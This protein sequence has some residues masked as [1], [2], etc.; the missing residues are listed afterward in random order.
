MAKTV[1]EI[2]VHRMVRTPD[3]RTMLLQ[4]YLEEKLA[5]QRELLEEEFCPAGAD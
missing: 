1:G 2:P 3:G 5:M 4:K